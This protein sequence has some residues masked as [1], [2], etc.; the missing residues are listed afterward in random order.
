MIAA[1]EIE[2]IAAD[3]LA[4]WGMLGGPDTITPIQ[5][6]LLYQAMQRFAVHTGDA[7]TPEGFTKQITD[8]YSLLQDRTRWEIQPNGDV[9]ITGSRGDRYTVTDDLCSGP[10]WYSKGKPATICRGTLNAQSSVCYHQI[11]R[12]LLRLAQV[13]YRT[14]QD[15]TPPGPTV[16]TVV[17]LSGTHLLALFGFAKVAGSHQP[18][19]MLV[20]TNSLSLEVSEGEFAS[21]PAERET[22][23]TVVLNLAPTA[24]AALWAIVRPYGKEA[25]AVKLVVESDYYAEMHTLSLH[26]GVHTATVAVDRLS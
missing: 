25:G 5:D 6:D 16:T 3:P 10:V 2:P 15:D 23:E 19:T 20:G 26:I 1:E 21:V 13:L 9:L 8:A 17:M 12:E 22:E 11:A 4:P 7:A 24:F 18:L 14:A